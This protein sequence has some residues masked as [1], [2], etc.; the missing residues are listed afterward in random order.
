VAIVISTIFGVPAW[1]TFRKN[2]LPQININIQ[3]PPSN[4]S[5][6]EDHKATIDKKNE[7]NDLKLDK[8][9]IIYTWPK[10][11]AK[12]ISRDLRTFSIV[13]DREMAHGW[14]ISGNEY[15]RLARSEVIHEDRASIFIFK[16]EGYENKLPPITEIRLTINPSDHEPNFRDLNGNPAPKDVTIAFT[17]GE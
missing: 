17:T 2:Q 7:M 13:F 12:N 1:L 4:F 14:S 10:D 16:R 3:N 6:T 8:P 5:D 15:F 11:K 9:Q